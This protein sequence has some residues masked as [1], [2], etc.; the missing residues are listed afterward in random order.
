MIIEDGNWKVVRD[1]CTSG[2]C[3]TCN[4]KSPFGVPLRV[5][6]MDAIDERSAKQVAIN[7]RSYK[8][9]A[10]PMDERKST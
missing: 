5:T 4:G 2:N 8:A 6:Q 7:W 1:C 9:V 10:E 3:I